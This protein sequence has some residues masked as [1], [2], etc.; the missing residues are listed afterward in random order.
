MS[1]WQSKDRNL[2][3]NVLKIKYKMFILANAWEFFL[4]LKKTEVG[5]ARL[6]AIL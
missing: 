3:F 2:F 1:Q 6:L 4:Y 5:I